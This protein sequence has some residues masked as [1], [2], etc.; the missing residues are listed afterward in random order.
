MIP[1]GEQ[2]KLYEMVLAKAREQGIE[3]L[4]ED[5]IERAFA[6]VVAPNRC[7]RAMRHMMA[8]GLTIEDVY[9]LRVPR[10]QE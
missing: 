10:L 1:L 4:C 9:A 7:V 8:H 2:K 6:G 5:E 3:R